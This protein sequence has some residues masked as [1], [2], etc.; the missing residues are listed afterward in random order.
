M[1]CC[2]TDILGIYAHTNNEINNKNIKYKATKQL[3]KLRQEIFT[4]HNPL[5]HSADS[6]FT[7]FCISVCDVKL[8]FY[9]NDF[10]S[11]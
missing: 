4:S 11:L 9:D 7:D 1:T 6:V 8:C 2:L 10:S 5:L 3:H